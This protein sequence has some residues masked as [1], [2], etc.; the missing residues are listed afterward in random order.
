MNLE[1]ERRV[2]RAV[3]IRRAGE[4]Q[5]VASDVSLADQLVQGDCRAIEFQLAEGLE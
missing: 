1:S 2:A 5:L 3:G 4:L